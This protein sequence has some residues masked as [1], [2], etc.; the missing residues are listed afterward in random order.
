MVVRRFD[1]FGSDSV[2]Q[3]N[4]SLKIAVGKLAVDDIPRFLFIVM[5]ARAPYGYDISA[6]RNFDLF[7]V[8]SGWPV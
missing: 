2:W 8:N 3:T 1:V 7:W 4:L 6:D 5:L